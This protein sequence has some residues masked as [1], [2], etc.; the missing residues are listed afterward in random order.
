MKTVAA[1]R[2]ARF[3]YEIL[4]TIEAGIM[5]TGPEV[6][7]VRGGHIDLRGAYVSFHGNVPTLKQTTIAPYRYAADLASYLPGRDRPL[8]LKKSEAAKLQEQAEQKGVTIVPLEVKAGKYIKIVLGIARGRK[9][10]DKRSR[11]RERE[12]SKKLRR[13]EEV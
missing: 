8:L 7:S 10:I 13:G 6:K 11:I 5:L 2:R 9:T 3:D 4:E 12:M 1:N